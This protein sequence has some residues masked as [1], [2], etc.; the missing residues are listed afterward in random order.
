MTSHDR[1]ISI[2]VMQ[3]QYFYKVPM[4]VFKV[5]ILIALQLDVFVWS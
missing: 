5:S 2:A 4:C 3:E 1:L